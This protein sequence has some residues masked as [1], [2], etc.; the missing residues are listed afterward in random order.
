MIDS[1][2]FFLIFIPYIFNAL[3]YLDYLDYQ[4]IQNKIQYFE[5]INK[6]G[7]TFEN[8][9]FDKSDVIIVN[10]YSIDCYVKLS[11]VSFVNLNNDSFSI[12]FDE[13]N[14]IENLTIVP[15]FE[16]YKEIR[17]CDLIANTINLKNNG[18]Q[19]NID[20]ELKAPIILYF[21]DNTMATLTYK[22]TS[23]KYLSF[24]FLF[25]ELTDFHII[26]S[27]DN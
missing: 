14:K 16:N 18:Y 24:S 20:E 27:K 4:F 7:I 21:E 22:S 11:V 25:D 12:K 5:N 15:L 9:L 19:L 1:I 23:D 8:I 3:D 17:T 2:F 6:E 10:L 26:V 13:T